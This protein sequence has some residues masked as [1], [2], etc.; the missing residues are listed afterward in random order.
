MELTKA[1]S[2]WRTRPEDQRFLSLIDMDEFCNYQAEHSAAKVLPLHN[3]TAIPNGPNGMM[4]SGQNGNPAEISNY[5][6][7][8]LATRIGAPASYLRSLPATLAADNINHSLKSSDNDELGILLFKNGG[9]TEVRAVTGPTYGRI[10]NR[11]ITESLIRRFGDGITGD[12]RVPGEFGKAIEVTTENTTL[13]ASDRDMFVFLADETNKISVPNRRDGK[14]GEMSRGFFVWNSEVGDCTLGFAT[15]LFDYACCNRIVWGAQGYEEIKV[16]HTSGAPDRWIGEITPT[17]R[18]YAASS[19]EPVNAML[20]ASQAAKISVIGTVEAFLGARF[21]KS[22]VSAIIAAHQAD[23]GR[24]IESLWDAAT[25][26]TAYAR[27]ITHQND[28]VKLERAAGAILK[29]AA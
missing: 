23:E 13:Y 6:F 16:R 10:W 14:S 9:P 4:L 17:L 11:E 15:F 18:R 22:Q 21:T 26:I 28:R 1:S 24:P 2:Q 25:G 20:K 12:F 5:A 19:A 27:S 7:G 8:Q 3:L 29:L